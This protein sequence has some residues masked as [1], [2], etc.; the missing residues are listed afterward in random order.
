MDESIGEMNFNY[1]LKYVIVG[2][3]SV[4]KS[5]LLLRYI[6]NTFK[7]EY[8]LTIGVSFGEKKVNSLGAIKLSYFRKFA[9][10][11]LIEP[12]LIEDFPEI[13]EHKE[14]KDLDDKKKKELEKIRKM[15]KF[16]RHYLSLKILKKINGFKPN[17]RVD[18]SITKFA[19]VL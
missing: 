4:G 18:F 3:A 13:T 15:N 11:G 2:D 5:N 7:A 14:E 19:Q 10:N 6:F 12:E 9:Y 8:Q 16:E 17:S 1:L